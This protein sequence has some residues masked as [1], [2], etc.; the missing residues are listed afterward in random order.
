MELNEGL[1]N[2]IV[3]Q[4][5]GGTGN[6]IGKNGKIVTDTSGQNEKMP[7]GVMEKELFP[8]VKNQ[9]ETVKQA[10]SQKQLESRPRNQL[11]R[12]LDGKDE[13]PAHKQEDQRRQNLEPMNEKDLEKDA[14]DSQPPGREEQRPAPVAAQI[15]QGKRSVCSRDEKI[16]GRVVENPENLTPTFMKFENV[17]KSKGRVGDD[18]ACAVNG[19]THDI[20]AIAGVSRMADQGDQPRQT[21]EPADGGSES[22]GDLGRLVIA[23]VHS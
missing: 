18:Q 1:F 17:I 10:S 20:P 12:G 13:H 23:L 3:R 22:V 6:D 5:G 21:E 14:Q 11:D 7:D 9:P 16:Y 15:N 2:E 19:A 8:D 4:L